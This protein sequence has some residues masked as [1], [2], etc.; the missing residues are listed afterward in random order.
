MTQL[1]LFAPHTVPDGSQRL[2]NGCVSVIHTPDG[3]TL[4][5][6][7]TS[8]GGA[9]LELLPADQRWLCEHVINWGSDELHA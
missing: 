9:W 6:V 3:R 1:P 2:S 4:L 8:R 5:Y 7:N